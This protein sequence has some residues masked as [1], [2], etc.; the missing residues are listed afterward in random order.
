MAIKFIFISPLKFISLFLTYI[1]GLFEF[2]REETLDILG[3]GDIEMTTETTTAV[4]VSETLKAEGSELAAI[5]KKRG[6]RDRREFKRDIEA[7]GF[8]VRLG[9]LMLDLEAATEGERIPSATLKAVGVNIISSALRSEWKWFV[10]NET[11]AREFIKASKKGFTNVSALKSA[12]AKAAKAEAKAEASTEG[13]SES[14]ATEGEAS[15][16]AVTE[17]ETV[18]ITVET[19]AIA[20]DLVAKRDG[21]TVEDVMS[22]VIDLFA[23]SNQPSDLLNLKIAA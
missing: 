20:I 15:E 16:N 14:E 23:K 9:Q 8:G 6:T 7:D 17:G 10:L 2:L 13:E 21:K 22:E 18:P 12:M 19:I 11:S 5:A 4:A 1:C 3:I